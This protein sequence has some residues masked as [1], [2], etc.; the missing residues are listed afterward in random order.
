MSTIDN[1]DQN[2]RFTKAFVARILA[3]LAFVCLGTFAV[4]QSVMSDR[5]N[6]QDTQANSIT[7]PD[8][9]A[10]QTAGDETQ[11]KS[12]LKEPSGEK[13]KQD[14]TKSEAKFGTAKPGA[15]NPPK[16]KSFVPPPSNS[17]GSFN[18]KPATENRLKKSNKFGETKQPRTIP[19]EFNANKKTV[20]A[21]PT[22][23]AK[24]P[25]A[26]KSF[27]DNSFGSGA[28][29]QIP[30]ER[31][32][33]SQDTNKA[34]GKSGLAAQTAPSSAPSSPFGKP[35]PGTSNANPVNS[36]EARA[37]SSTVD[38]ATELLNSIQQKSSATAKDVQNSFND[39]AAGFK[40]EFSKET[41]D[42]RRGF[43][44]ARAKTTPV[45][46]TPTTGA[47]Q[48]D[49]RPIGLPPTQKQPAS[50]FNTRPDL[51][52]KSNNMRGLPARK[53][54]EQ[55]FG[56]P[57][58]TS[59][60]KSGPVNP[61][62]RNSNQPKSPQNSFGNP[63]AL[64]ARTAP[65]SQLPNQQSAPVKQPFQSIAATPGRSVPIKPVSSP[66]PIASA[67]NSK[68]TPGDRQLEGAQTPALTIEKIAPR[69][70]QL[71]QPADFVIVVRNTGRVQANQ[72]QVTDQIPTGAE[73]LTADPQPNRTGRGDLVWNLGT[74][75]AGQEKRI[76]LQ[77]RPTRPG[78]IGS[79]ANVTFSS[80]ASMRT[81]VTKPM[82]EVQHNGPA[83]VLVGD[84]VIL[85]IV[86]E[87]KGDGPANNIMLEET[88]PQQLSYRDGIDREI[89][90]PLG[91][92][93]PGQRKTI[94]LPLKAAKIGKLR[95]VIF[96][97]AD[98]GLDAQHA[99]DMEVIAPQLVTRGT[100][101]R[102]RYLNREA[103]HQFSVENAGTAKAT[104]VELVG[105][106]PGGL[107][108]VSAN[109]RGK[110]DPN[111][112]A[113]YWSLAELTP[114]M[115]ANVELKTT[116]VEAG[117]Q[118]IE[119]E[120]IADLKQQ[121]STTQQLMVEHLIDVFFD[122]DD[123][124]DPIEVGSTTSYRIRVVNQGTKTATN[125]RVQVDFPAGITPAAVDGSLSSQIQGQQVI[126]A[127][128]TSINPGDEIKFT[129]HGKGSAPGDHL[130]VVRLQTDGRETNVSKGET[131]HV[132]QDR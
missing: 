91:T 125:V 25:P 88:I 76:K 83:Q 6:P 20:V 93:G 7:E 131:T 99:I 15:A 48:N 100:G 14:Q 101:P 40:N 126:F 69:E 39:A 35:A 52:P 68:N 111:T 72:V 1:D 80:Q 71:N 116:P 56:S 60:L 43:D 97:S 58:G 2:P 63:G 18:A 46:T 115:V 4:V 90:Y 9:V 73:L 110:Y 34:P 92:L 24:G 79:V 64:P 119:F 130:V 65:G 32:A 49:G 117:N 37:K 5:S 78:E 21:K 16:S 87:N 89:E 33:M 85:E 31:F 8:S 30:P 82:L 47:K 26:V 62:T 94:R 59:S 42:L 124:V 121:S 27:G 67:A 105:R 74:M 19:N 108:F 12:E 77:L 81:L 127:P 128:I 17:F 29:T 84:D 122:I 57:G 50:P 51:G 45:A 36:F 104:N 106:L 10:S 123:V 75:R 114:S 107:R 95:N 55:S 129:V 41:N 118:D 112:H 13:S 44:Q 22:Q 11:S 86:I 23:V 120:A 96:A 66:N 53:G 61:S 28:R 102:R 109:N 113:V 132:Y 98:G 38:S 3:V 70:I 103:T 54:F